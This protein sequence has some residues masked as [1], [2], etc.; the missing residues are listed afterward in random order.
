MM[1][2]GSKIKT[3]FREQKD[4]SISYV[5]EGALR[6]QLEQYG[7][8]LDFHLESKQHTATLEMHLRGDDRPVRLIIHEYEIIQNQSG[9]FVQVKRA[10]VS[11]EWI[12][13]LLREFLLGRPFLVPEKYAQWAK[14]LL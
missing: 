14:M 6:K 5:V 8:V 4:A 3:W 10:T 13:L 12:D 11:K 2:T 1:S 7:Q 9:T